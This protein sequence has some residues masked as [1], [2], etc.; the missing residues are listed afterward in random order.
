LPPWTKDQELWILH[1]TV[2]EVK[3]RRKRRADAAGIESPVGGGAGGGG[4]GGGGGILAGTGASP[5][6][7]PEKAGAGADDG[8][9]CDM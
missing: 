3:Q 5:G 2:G 7:S 9:A 1:Q 8:L 4:G 6:A